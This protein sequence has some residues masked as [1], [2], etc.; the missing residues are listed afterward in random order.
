MR[1]ISP[2]GRLPAT[3]YEGA[4]AG[5]CG[6][7]IGDAGQCG[8]RL[9][10]PREVEVARVT[11][12]GAHEDMRFRMGFSVVHGLGSRLALYGA[13]EIGDCHG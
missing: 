1:K 13:P 10:V 8:L 7:C 6:Q 5:V 11:H 2:K 9:V 12:L 3:K 4:F